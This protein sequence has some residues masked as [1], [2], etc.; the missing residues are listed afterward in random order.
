MLDLDISRAQLDR[1]IAQVAQGDAGALDGLYGDTSPRLYALCLSILPD[2][3]AAEAAL[4]DTY[5]RVWSTAAD[6]EGSGLPAMTWL[7]ALARDAALDRLQDHAV[8]RLSGDDHV[9]ATVQTWQSDAVAPAMALTPILPPARARQMIRETLG[10]VAPPL[11]EDPLE[12]APRGRWLLA[13]ALLA[14]LAAIW[15]IMFPV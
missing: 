3:P 11:T 10:H 2:R 1:M 5:L 6:H 15:W 8:A 13:L 14:T 7:I 12:P 9:A 4:Q